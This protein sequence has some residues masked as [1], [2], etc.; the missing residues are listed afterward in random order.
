MEVALAWH[1]RRR[2]G[3]SGVAG[4]ASKD[5]GGDFAIALAAGA[6]QGPSEYNQ[7]MLNDGNFAKVSF[8]NGKLRRLLPRARDSRGAPDPEFEVK[9]HDEAM[10][11]MYSYNGPDLPAWAQT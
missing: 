10:T 2:K 5:A 8:T 4:C 3:V 9:F 7:N 11:H 1:G 6:R